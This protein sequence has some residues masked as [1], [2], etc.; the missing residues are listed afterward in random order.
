MTY[1]GSGS[2][3]ALGVRI[4]R[5]DPSGAPLV[6]AEN[7]YCTKQMVRIGLGEEFSEPDAVEQL[8]GSGE[9]CVYYQPKPTLLRGTI[10][11]FQLCVPD[12]Y[13]KT[14]LTGGELIAEGGTLEVQQVAITGTPTSGTFTLGYAGETTAPIP[15]DAD[16]AEVEAALEALDALN[17]DDV[18]VTGGPLPD[19]AVDVT[20]G[21][22]YSSSN[23]EEMTADGAGLGG[24]TT[25]AVTVTTTQEGA[26]GA[27][28]IGY[29]APLVNTDPNP[30]GVA[31]EFWTRK[32]LNN[33]FD[34]FFHWILPRA[35]VR[36][37]ESLTASH[38]DALTLTFEGSCEQNP[39][40][41]DGPE[42]DILIPTDRIYQ[43]YA[44]DTM[45]DVTRG[46]VAVIA[47]A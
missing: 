7:S 32:L 46:P 3:F 28:V 20:F 41:G 21:Q 37:S 18:A 19:I 24:G 45:P 27:T 2:L 9:T 25:P 6:G 4:T 14:L 15:F 13:V 1:D 43:W 22:T 42:N 30:D 16:A 17:P 35:Q 8:N 5:L 40:F 23:V 39:N 33:A 47:D 34:G 38:E 31:I 29:R 36:L 26:T 10:E 12:P 11:E 44:V